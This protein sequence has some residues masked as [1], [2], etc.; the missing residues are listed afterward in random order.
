MCCWSCCQTA[1]HCGHVYWMEPSFKSQGF[2]L[3]GSSKRRSRTSLVRSPQN[4]Q[5]LS[6][7]SQQ[8]TPWA[9]AA[10]TLQIQ[11]QEASSEG[12][13]QLRA[14]RISV[15]HL[16]LF[17][18]PSPNLPGF[19]NYLC[20]FITKEHPDDG[21]PHVLVVD[22]HKL[23]ANIDIFKFAIGNNFIRRL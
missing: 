1:G 8:S 11:G 14:S 10:S 23:H 4:M 13:R 7:F 6:R 5:K 2:G 17:L 18:H 12:D 20:A 3:G 16:G 15:H 9:S 21:K 19:T 22:R